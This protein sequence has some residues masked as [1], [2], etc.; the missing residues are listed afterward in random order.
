MDSSTRPIVANLFIEEFEI[1]IIKLAHHPPR[2]WLRY[3]DDTI[4]M[5]KAEHSN[6]ILQ[7][8]NSIDPNI[9]FTEEMADQQGSIPFLDTLV[10][11]GPDTTLLTPVYRKPTHTQTNTYTGTATIIC[12]PSTLCIEPSYI[13]LWQFVLHPAAP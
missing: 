13:V 7:H 4:V 3:L 12:Q 10:L 9:W 1:K 2:L 5:Q 8:I 11:P 6:H